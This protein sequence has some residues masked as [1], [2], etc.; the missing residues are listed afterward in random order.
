LLNTLGMVH[1]Q[2]LNVDGDML[3]QFQTQSEPLF[4]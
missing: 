3:A 1:L 4:V 2:S